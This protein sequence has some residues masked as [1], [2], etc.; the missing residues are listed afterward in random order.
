MENAESL[1]KQLRLSQDEIDFYRK[2]AKENAQKDKRDWA[3][4]INMYRKSGYEDDMK[5][6]ATYASIICLVL[7]VLG[8]YLVKLT[9]WVD[10]NKT[11]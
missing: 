2:Q 1:E 5:T 11:K 6:N 10:K 4:T 3:D 8:R 7:C 9:K